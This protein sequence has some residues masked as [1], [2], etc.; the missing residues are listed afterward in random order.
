MHTHTRFAGQGMTSRVLGHRLDK[1]TLDQQRM[2]RCMK[3]HRER[4]KADEQVAKVNQREHARLLLL[5]RRNC[6]LVT[7]PHQHKSRVDLWN[8][9]AEEHKSEK[10]RMKMNKRI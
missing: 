9:P 8:Q 1:L 3:S 2:K 5:I 4:P 10:K 6:A 7:G